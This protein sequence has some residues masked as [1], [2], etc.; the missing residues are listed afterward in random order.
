MS[1][2]GGPLDSLLVWIESFLSDGTQLQYEDLMEKKYLF[3]ALQQ[4]DPRPLWSEPI[5]EC[6]DQASQLHNASILYVQLLTCYAETLNQTVL[7]PMLDLNAYVNYEEDLAASQLEMHRLLMLFLGIAIQC[8][9]KDEFIAAMETLPD[10]IQEDIMEN[11]RTLAQ[12]LVRLDAAEART[13]GAGLRKCC[14]DRL[15]CFKKYSEAVEEKC[16]LE[17]VVLHSQAAEE[18]KPGS[19]PTP[20]SSQQSN[21][22]DVAALDSANQRAA[23]LAAQ[24][25][26]KTAEAA[27]LNEKLRRQ[28]DKVQRLKATAAKANA[29]SAQGVKMGALNEE[30][31]RLKDKISKFENMEKEVYTLRQRQTEFDFYK[32]RVQELRTEN[33]QLVEDR[34][35]FEELLYSSRRKE[36]DVIERLVE[37]QMRCDELAGLREADAERSRQALEAAASAGGE[38]AVA[39]IR[40]LEAE[41]DRLRSTGSTGAAASGG[42]SA[43]DDKQERWKFLEVKKEL[44]QTR[45]E[46]AKA[47][48]QAE[49]DAQRAK[50][51]EAQLETATKAGADREHELVGT[52]QSHE[53]HVRDLERRIHELTN[54]IVLLKRKGSEAMKGL[55]EAELAEMEV[56]FQSVQELTS[57]VSRLKNNN[58]ILRQSCDKLKSEVYKIFTIEQENER[59]LAENRELR[60]TKAADST[61][62]DEWELVRKKNLQL[63]VENKKLRRIVESLKMTLVQIDPYN[64]MRYHYITSL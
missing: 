40:E 4:I 57:Q 6:L 58:K 21:P 10:E 55:R 53:E 20:P 22:A 11:Y 45:R 24:L 16:Y 30:I 47:R 27:K 60:K 62:Q 63:E 56:M 37:C 23:Q 49:T 51:A 28:K 36:E 14:N 31:E 8:K 43:S 15:D 48:K 44:V 1:Q 32:S 41:V 34:Q 61:A 54:Q 29:G 26:A 38:Q 25:E 33:S 59:L 39:R 46:L 19:S 12:H 7:L 3:N 64:K 5:D 42:P 52:R 9:R 50:R 13:G 2:K 35:H 17:T 18:S